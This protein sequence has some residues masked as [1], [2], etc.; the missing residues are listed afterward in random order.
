LEQ[1]KKPR[2]LATGSG[3]GIVSFDKKLRRELS[4]HS[5]LGPATCCGPGKHHINPCCHGS[6]APASSLFHDT[7]T[8]ARY[9]KDPTGSEAGKAR[10][11]SILTVRLWSSMRLPD[12]HP[13]AAVRRA[14][15]GSHY[16]RDHLLSLEPPNPPETS[17]EQVRFQ[18]APGPSTGRTIR[19][20]V[21]A[22]Y[23]L[24]TDRLNVSATAPPINGSTWKT[25]RRLRWGLSIASRGSDDRNRRRDA[26]T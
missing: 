10:T 23:C 12:G 3:A 21:D 6:V 16:T 17:L 4:R 19:K 24:S 1:Q 9:I 7:S 14:A 5:V 20:S 22:V 8:I 18:S 11:R 13:S 2:N 25:L 15:P 26:R